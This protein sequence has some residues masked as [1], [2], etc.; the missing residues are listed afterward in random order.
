M[1]QIIYQHFK[2][3]ISFARALIS[4]CTSF[5]LFL[6]LFF[7]QHATAKTEKKGAVISQD[8]I[9][10]G[11]RTLK[12]IRA[13]KVRKHRVEPRQILAASC[14]RVSLLYNYSYSHFVLSVFYRKKSPQELYYTKHGQRIFWPSVHVLKRPF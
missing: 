3:N 8:G 7:G 2:S 1:Q 11:A 14:Y 5:D 13:Q 12:S 9:D 6:P 4:F 10:I